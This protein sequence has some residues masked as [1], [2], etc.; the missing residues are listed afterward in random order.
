MGQHA[1]LRGGEIWLGPN[2]PDKPYIRVTH[3]IWKIIRENPR[4]RGIHKNR[5]V[6]A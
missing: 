1:L 5:A 3:A 6:A 4:W 2:A